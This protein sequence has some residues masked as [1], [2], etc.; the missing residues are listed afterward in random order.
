[1][2][3]APQR[4]T[5]RYAALAFEVTLS[6]SEYVAV[7]TRFGRDGTLG[8]ECFLAAGEKPVQRLLVIRARRGGASP[9]GETLG[10]SVPAAQARYAARGTGR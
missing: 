1:M 10:V 3:L 9:A 5:E 4:P 2:S 6:E 8:G 7:G